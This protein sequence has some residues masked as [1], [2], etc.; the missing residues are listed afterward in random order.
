MQLGVQAEV[1]PAAPVRVRVAVHTGEAVVIDGRT[2]GGPALARCE[3]LLDLAYGGQVLVSAATALLVQD[4]M[5]ADLVLRQLPAVGL[6]GA[7][8]PEHPSQLEHPDLERIFPPLRSIEPGARLPS[9]P[10]SF[11]GREADIE[12]LRELVVARRVVTVTG[13]GGSGKT[14]LAHQVASAVEDMFSDGVV[15]VDLGRVDDG[16]QVAPETAAACGLAVSPGGVEEATMLGRHLSSNH[17][18]VVLDNCEHVLEDAAAVVDVVVGRDG[19]SVVLATSR[20]PLG[21][22]GEVVWRIP[23]LE[24]PDATVGAERAG[25]ASAVALF[26]ERAQAGDPGFVLDEE[27]VF[28]VVDVCRRL[29]GIPLAIELAAAR[30]RT[31]SL[32]TLVVGLDDRFR[33]LAGGPRSLKRQRTLQA[34]ID[35]SHDLLDKRERVAFRRLSVFA[36]GFRLDDAEAVL[37]DGRLARLEIMELVASLVDKSLVQRASGR[38]LLLESVRRYANQKAAD[39]GELEDLR[40][41]HLRHLLDLTER[42]ELHREIDSGATFDELSGLVTDLRAALAWGLSV[43]RGLASPLVVPLVHALNTAG[44]LGEVDSLMASVLEGVPAGSL[45]WCGLVAEPILIMPFL[46]EWWRDTAAAAVDDLGDQLDP[47]TRRR[48][49]LGLLTVDLMVGVHGAADLAASLIDEA[50]QER[51]HRFA[52]YASARLAYFAAIHGDV[53]RA[54]SCLDWVKHHTPE[55]NPENSNAWSARIIIAGLRCDMEATTAAVSDFVADSHHDRPRAGDVASMAIRGA[56]FT[57]SLP[58]LRAV[59]AAIQGQE[60]S[61]I[62]E[63]VPR[64]ADL[65]LALLESDLPEALRCIDD[66]LAL[67]LIER[68]PVMHHIAADVTLACGDRDRAGEHVERL[69]TLCEGVDAPDAFAGSF[70][71]RAQLAR[72]DGHYKHA[73]ELAHRA[74]DLA[75][76]HQLLLAR[77]VILEDLALLA[78]DLGQPDEAARLLGACEA[79]RARTRY[80]MR[81]PHRACE[82]DK[83]RAALDAVA[84]EEGTTLTIDDAIRYARRGRGPRGRPVEGWDALTPAEQ[85]VSALIADGRSNQDVAHALFVTVATVKTHV[86]HIYQKLDLRSRAQLV[87]AFHLRD[88]P[89]TDRTRVDDVPL[90]GE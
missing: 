11:V 46:G 9:F 66:V 41:R 79:F 40:H 75:D 76:L 70:R 25:D 13:S 20:E 18:L 77:V 67:P 68:M 73:A 82:L 31:M 71:L 19:R 61:G 60:F 85:Q 16:A 52:I 3:R 65:H 26:V 59:R 83:L 33:L 35:W 39:A 80:G 14:R 34:S 81:L 62:F 72:L 8:R 15:W 57:G 84:V 29:D 17:R 37:P 88:R 5:L 30:L 50:R 55:G 90:A 58:L 74:L 27:T 10:T 63:F 78:G 23:S 38:Y 47:A 86:A 6:E 87:R 89:P 45:E 48:L 51:D 44:R 2:S 32:E 21:V 12:R 4:T 28:A 49:R 69:Q 53:A 43:D 56:Y 7:D 1:W 36:S 24:V 22:A 64:W 54:E 42:G